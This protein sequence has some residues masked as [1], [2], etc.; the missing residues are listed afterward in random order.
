MVKLKKTE[1]RPEKM[2]AGQMQAEWSRSKGERKRGAREIK[3]S[4]SNSNYEYGP[5]GNGEY[6]ECNADFPQSLIK[7]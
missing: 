3:A 7:N 1:G 6:L 2:P 4:T 5:D